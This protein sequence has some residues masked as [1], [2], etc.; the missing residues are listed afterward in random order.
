[1]KR[2]IASGLAG[3]GLALALA[4]GPAGARAA[5]DDQMCALPGVVQFGF[6]A[7][8]QPL[9]LNAQ[10]QLITAQG[11]AVSVP[12]FFLNGQG[13]LVTPQGVVISPNG[14][15]MT[16]QGLALNPQDLDDAAQGALVSCVARNAPHDGR[17]QIVSA[18]AR[19]GIDAADDS[20]VLGTLVAQCLGELGNVNTG[21]ITAAPVTTVN[22]GR[23]DD[24]DHNGR[25]EDHGRGND[26]GPRGNRGRGH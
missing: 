25:G 18:V 4:G 24:D 8:P 11:V 23:G 20:V 21:A 16:P 13:Q 12:G 26:H 19:E 10:G 22:P 6:Q 2:L 7:C 14:F 5:P 9:F 1:M 3:I 15:V 17:G